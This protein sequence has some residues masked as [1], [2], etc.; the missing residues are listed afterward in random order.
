MWSYDDS[1]IGGNVEFSSSNDTRETKDA[2]QSNSVAGKQ[3]NP[4][5]MSDTMMKTR[6]LDEGH[7][8]SMFVD[9]AF[10]WIAPSTLENKNRANKKPLICI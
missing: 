1:W 6:H 2:I 8:S 5:I 9:S 7:C 3:E 4:R 10:V